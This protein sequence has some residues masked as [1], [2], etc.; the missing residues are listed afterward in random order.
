MNDQ[1]SNQHNNDEID[2]RELVA[3][4]WNGKW[5]IGG[6]TAVF[7][8]A[9]VIVVL[10]LPNQYK[11]TAVLA[12]AQSGS[13]SL[14]GALAAQ[15]GGLASLA[16]ISLGAGESD[17]A[18][19]A[20]EIMK[21]WGFIDKFIKKQGIEVEVF[22]VEEWDAG[23]KQ[24]IIDNALYD[25]ESN[26]WVRNPS[27]GKPVE[28]TSWEL[29]EV[30]KKRLS[31]SQAKDTGLVS[32]SIEYYSPQLSKQWVD[33][34]IELINNH[35]RERKLEQV[36]S[37]IEYLQTQIEKTSISEMKE[38]F[39]QIIEE[40]TKSKMLAEASPE[41]AFV[42]VSAAMVAEE[43]SKPKRALLSVLWTTLGCV[44][45]IIWVLTINWVKNG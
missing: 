40:Q 7:A 14:S 19:I 1:P 39:Y 43:K 22:A 37:N 6:M 3:T 29:Y 4:L 26:K 8:V 20:M 34:Y 21:S 10:M 27:S 41:Y 18:Q 15:F 11:A 38:V 2:L 5:I 13:A 36:N 28:P 30:F 16:G 42:T 24:L 25:A 23:N 33:A 35:M 45:T 12:P 44:L 31:I 17:E 32:V 9:A